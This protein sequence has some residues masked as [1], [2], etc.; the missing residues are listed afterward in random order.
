MDRACHRSD[1]GD[2]KGSVDEM[3]CMEYQSPIRTVAIWDVII[4]GRYI[5]IIIRRFVW[6]RYQKSTPWKKISLSNS[7]SA[8]DG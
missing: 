5:I 8:G 6:M 3:V 7:S 2:I 4:S 1:P